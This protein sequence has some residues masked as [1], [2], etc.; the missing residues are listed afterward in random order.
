V[1]ELAFFGK[2][3]PFPVQFLDFIMPEK[4]EKERLGVD[5]RN[6]DKGH[7]RKSE[8]NINIHTQETVYSMHGKKMISKNSRH[9]K[10][11]HKPDSQSFEKIV[12]FCFILN[13][14]MYT[15]K[16]ISGKITL[17]VRCSHSR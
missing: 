1:K 2:V 3:T 8:E 16:N 13:L 17:P 9:D 11:N 6:H 14:S 4:L 10:K 5:D 7:Q 15:G 12:L